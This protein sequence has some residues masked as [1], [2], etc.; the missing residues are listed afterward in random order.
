MGVG[1]STAGKKLAGKMGREFLDTDALFE[2]RYKLSISSFFAKYGEDLFRKLENEILKSTFNMDNCVISTGG[3]LPCYGDSMDEIN[4]NGISIY[5]EMSVNAI[6][7]RLINS[8]QKRPLIKNMTEQQLLHFIDETLAYRIKYY[9][10]SNITIDALSVDVG[11]LK[12]LVS[13]KFNR[14]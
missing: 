6:F 13:Y 11:K 7:S 4:N 9:S 14:Y 1:K 2:K 12:E 8:K 10:K 3:G 5:M